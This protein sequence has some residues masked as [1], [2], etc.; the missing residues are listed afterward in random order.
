MSTRRPPRT[1]AARSVEEPAPDDVDAMTDAVLTA[2]RVLVAVSAR[3]IV[4]V[5]ESITIPQLRL[6]VVLDS[7]GPLKLTTFA[8]HLAVN[9]S[10]ATWM[11]DRLVANRDGQSG[12][13]PRFPSR[14]GRGAHRHGVGR[15]PGS[16]TAAAGT[17]VVSR[18]R[19]STRR[20]LVRALTA[21]TDA[22]D[23]PSIV[24]RADALWL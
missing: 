5:D 1:T 12:G 21:F 17:R 3:S 23:K 19:P 10:T 24:E 11:V 20:W 18:M 22:A 8:E 14:V 13:E 7:R 15:D 6:L 9:P 4:S 2:S 16:D